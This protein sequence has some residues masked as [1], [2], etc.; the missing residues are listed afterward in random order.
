YGTQVFCPFSGRPVSFDNLWIID[1]LFTLPLLVAVVWGLLIEVKRW[2]KGVGVKMTAVCI[3]LSSCYVGLS[4][5]AKASVS[6]H[7][8]ADFEARGMAWERKKESPAPFSILLWRA[9]VERDN[10]FW[11]GYRS[12]LDG[13]RSIVWT[14]YPKQHEAAKRWEEASEV[15]SVVRFSDGWFIARETRR[16]VWLVDMRFGAYR[17][18]DDRGLELRPIFA[19]EYQWDGRGDPLKSRMKEDRDSGEM[20]KRMWG[21]IWGEREAWSGRPRLI[22]NPAVAQEYLPQV[23]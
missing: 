6:S 21:R 5:W 2:R 12:L 18:W 11:V 17:E 1:P 14:I 10:E 22:G 9:V 15:A 23:N 20:L 16:G 19:W 13:D 8:V 4:F 3:G 7:V